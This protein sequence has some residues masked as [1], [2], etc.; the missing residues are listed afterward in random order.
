MW[1]LLVTLALISSVHAQQQPAHIGSIGGVVE[2]QDSSGSGPT[3][4]GEPLTTPEVIRTGVGSFVELLLTTNARATAGAQSQ[5]E[6]R[7]LG[8][9]PLIWLENGTI[10]VV[11]QD[12]DVQVQTKSGLFSAA[13]WPVEMEITKS[14]GTV[15]V[16]VTEGRIKVQNLDAASVT[17]GAP[18]NKAYRTYTTGRIDPRTDSAPAPPPNIWVQPSPGR[19][20]S[21]APAPTPQ[22]KH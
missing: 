20:S 14:A 18:E 17:F 13:E 12:A 19:N 1:S 15:N 4:I 2:T 6:I 8:T 11:S 10:K 3:M 5:I 21:T 16:V 22:P 9:T 7:Q